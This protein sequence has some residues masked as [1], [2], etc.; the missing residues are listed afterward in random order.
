MLS[1]VCSIG[2]PLA[3]VLWKGGISF[4]VIITMAVTT[5]G[6]A[7]STGTTGAGISERPRIPARPGS[8]AM[9]PGRPAEPRCPL[10]DGGMLQRWGMTSS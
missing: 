5:A 3:A 2:M 8:R 9:L 1:F 10:A 7:R 6:T 4:G